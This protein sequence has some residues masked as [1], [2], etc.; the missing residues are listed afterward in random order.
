MMVMTIGGL[1]FRGDFF[2]VFD[3]VF[4]CSV[5]FCF[6]VRRV[7]SWFWC[8]VHLISGTREAYNPGSTN[9]HSPAHTSSLH[10]LRYQDGEYTIHAGSGRVC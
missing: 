10:T 4:F 3:F 7:L 2:A 1:L 8:C 9:E 6:V 5:L